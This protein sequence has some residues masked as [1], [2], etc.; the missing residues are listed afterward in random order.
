M[1]DTPRHDVAETDDRKAVANQ[2]DSRQ[3]PDHEL[4]GQRRP[5]GAQRLGRRVGGI[6]VDE[7]VADRAG[8]QH[9]RHR[10]GQAHETDGREEPVGRAPVAIGHERGKRSEAERLSE[11]ECDRVDAVRRKEGI[12]PRRLA[13]E[14]SD[15]QSENAAEHHHRGVPERQHGRVPDLRVGP[16]A[17]RS[18]H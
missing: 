17:L 3:K 5:E 13:V 14:V 4:A 18:L 16:Y 12:R 10:R 7:Q 15:Q 2:E 9:H 1:L 8:E 11:D 6:A